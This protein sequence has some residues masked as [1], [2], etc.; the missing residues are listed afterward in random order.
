MD[1]VEALARFRHA[2]DLDVVRLAVAEDVAD[3][4]PRDQR[5]RG[6]ADVTRLE[7]VLLRLL[8][9]D[10]DR[11]LWHL[12]ELLDVLLVQAVDAEQQLLDLGRLLPEHVEVVAVD[13]DD[14][15]L[16]GAR[17]HLPDALLQVGLHVAPD[18]RVAVDDLL[19]LASVSS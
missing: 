12:R 7:P 8:Q 5:G 17:Q 1:V 4:L 19:D 10:L 6:A 11:D 2:P 13:A 9:V 18:A 16:A 14:D 15:R 3:L